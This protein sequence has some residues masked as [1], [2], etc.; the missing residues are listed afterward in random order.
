M[1]SVPVCKNC[2]HER[3][4]WESPYPG[5]SAAGL[6]NESTVM[7]DPCQ[8]CGHLCKTTVSFDAD[9]EFVFHCEDV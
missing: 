8:L 6:V 1:S 3:H 2:G 5:G 7:V 9:G 4:D